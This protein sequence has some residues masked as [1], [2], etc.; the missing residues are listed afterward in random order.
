MPCGKQPLHSYIIVLGGEEW[1]C[2]ITSLNKGYF[3]LKLSSVLKALQNVIAELFKKNL[4]IL[5]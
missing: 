4:R 1:S 2:S 3:Y 5:K